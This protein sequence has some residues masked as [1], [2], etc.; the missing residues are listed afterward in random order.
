MQT[1]SIGRSNDNDIVIRDHSVSRHHA[2]LRIEDDGKVQLA[3]LGSTNGV[4]V[5]GDDEEWVQVQQ[6]YVTE[7]ERIMIGGT[8]TTVAALIGAPEGG[9]EPGTTDADPGPAQPPAAAATPAPAAPVAQTS[10]EQLDAPPTDPKPPQPVPPPGHVAPV[11]ATNIDPGSLN[12]GQ[13]PA[14]D[15]AP[16]QT[17]LPPVDAAAPDA[18]A[19]TGPGVRSYKDYFAEKQTQDGPVDGAPPPP[20]VATPARRR[21]RHGWVTWSAIGAAVLL[22]AG[23][24]TF[25]AIK[26]KDKIFGSAGTA[27]A[28]GTKQGPV[29]KVPRAYWSAT[30][31]GAKD[32]RA[33]AIHI[34]ANQG[35]IVAGYTTSA[36]KGG[37]DGWAVLIDKDGYKVREITYGGA[38]DDRIEGLIRTN[39]GNYLAVGRTKSKGKGDWDFWVLRLDPT[40]AVLWET[41][42]GGA[43]AD[44][45]RGAVSLRDG[46]FV[47]AG[48]TRS[49]T[50][51]A[52]ARGWLVKLDANGKQQWDLTVGNAAGDYE[53]RAIEQTAEGGFIVAGSHARPKR[54]SDIWLARVSKARK[55]VWQFATR[56]RAVD[57]ASAVFAS[58]RGTFLVAA[59]SASRSASGGGRGDAYIFGLTAKGKRKWAF[60]YGGRKLDSIDSMVRAS[61]GFI[62]S[63]FTESKGSGRRDL[64]LMKINNAGRHEWDKTFGG[65]GLDNGVG[66]LAL[67]DGSIVVA[68]NTNSGGA[69]GSDAWVLKLD[70]DGVIPGG[71]SAVGGGAAGG[72]TAPE[73]KA[74]EKKTPGKKAGGTTAKTKKR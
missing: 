35:F 29:E 9:L 24:G 64:W 25:A 13:V 8:A 10:P 70:K 50:K 30:F 41:V 63:G 72:S 53:I 2:E 56:G 61:D 27:T 17:D 54:G 36:G 1:Y 28:G 22:L 58:R 65:A 11:A 21:R 31:G 49:K 26:Y 51:N 45:A 62:L 43:A 38:Q 20:P 12:A 4:Y 48:N 23:A 52:S 60:A 66:V 7:T 68:G 15:V 46:G 39:D 47:V 44:I 6:A 55:V 5:Q 40:G 3:D 16:T 32:D 71:G 74:P 18:H 19:D 42:I 69:S 33:N 67:R 73:S 59:T 34:T 14:S 57:Y 37:E